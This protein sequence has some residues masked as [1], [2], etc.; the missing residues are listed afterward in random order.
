MSDNRQARMVSKKSKII[1]AVNISKQSAFGLGGTKRKSGIGG[2]D[3]PEE[4]MISL[5]EGL[6]RKNKILLGKT[7]AP[8]VMNYNLLRTRVNNSLTESDSVV[9]AVTSARPGE[10]KSTTS[11]NLALSLARSVQKDIILLDFDLHKPVVKEKLSLTVEKGLSD[12]YLGD[13]TLRDIILKD[14]N[15]GLYIIPGKE[16]VRNVEELVG[17]S[18]TRSLINDLKRAFPNRLIIMDTPPILVIDD[19]SV[20]MEYIDK[21][22]F[23]VSE[24]KSHKDDLERSIDLIGNEKLLGTVLNNSKDSR[25]VSSGYYD[26]YY[27]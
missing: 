14:K 10:G 6:I 8:A 16:E 5:D 12:Y 17:S 3:L 9:L 4:N 18:K 19:V 11:I 7:M 23:V 1:Q 15:T 21:I 22:L 26:Y 24:G 27:K 13:A 2:F 25:R 20:L